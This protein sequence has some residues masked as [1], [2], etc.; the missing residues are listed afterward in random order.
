MGSVN[1]L[2]TRE[3]V[4]SAPHQISVLNVAMAIL[5]ETEF[6]NLSVTYL[7]VH[8]APSQTFVISAFL[9]IIQTLVN[10]RILVISMVVKSVIP[11]TP[12]QLVE[13]DTN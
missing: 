12:V 11:P 8:H 2:A 9:D 1:Y 3:T 5:L 10:V 13:L 6:V 4:R 7:L